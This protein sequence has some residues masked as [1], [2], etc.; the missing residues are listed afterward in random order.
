MVRQSLSNCQ[1]ICHFNHGISDS[2]EQMQLSPNARLLYPH[3]DS[4]LIDAM[5][6]DQ[7]PDQLVVLDGTWHHAKTMVRDIPRLQRIP[8]VQLAPAVPG[9]YRIRREPNRYALSTLEA[10]VSALKILE[11]DLRDLDRLLHVFDSMIES[12]LRRSET[13]RGVVS[14]EPIAGT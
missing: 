12:Q 2:L 9:R 13:R 7:R 14:Y 11:P 1:L 6:I 3:P 5:P 4:P 8:K 10:V